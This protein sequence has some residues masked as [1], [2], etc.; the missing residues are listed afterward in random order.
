MLEYYKFNTTG[1]KTTPRSRQYVIVNNCSMNVA[2]Y[3]RRHNL[4]LSFDFLNY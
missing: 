2:F 3:V 1:D 4:F